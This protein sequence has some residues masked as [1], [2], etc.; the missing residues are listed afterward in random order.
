[1]SNAVETY[2]PLVIE[3]YLG[4]TSH[5]TTLQHGAYLLLLMA[6][7]RRGGALPDDDT[8]L[9]SIARLAPAEWRKHKPVLAEFF[10][11]AGGAW[12]QKRAEEELARA[13]RKSEAAAESARRRWEKD[14]G[15]D[16][17]PMRTHSG[18]TAKADA[19]PMRD[20][21][22]IDAPPSKNSPDANAS[23]RVSASRR[24]P[25]IPM[26]D[27]WAPKDR[28]ADAAEQRGINLAYQAQ[29]ARNWAA[30]NDARYADWDR[31]F[32]NWLLT[33][34]DDNGGQPRQQG[35]TSGQNWH[36]GN[37]D[38]ALASIRPQDRGGAAWSDFDG[39]EG[40]DRGGAA[41]LAFGPR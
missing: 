22:E 6:Y 1:M 7:W 13:R 10:Q 37:L 11:I 35:A 28:H 32:D 20:E 12:T 38:A 15:G 36:R 4:D 33:A 24:K 17:K 14:S 39:P 30:A 29:K 21:C 31:F 3:K 40:E 9:M 23:G 41:V 16:A 34:R 26:P 27:D 5:L 2:M 19:K 18:R 25:K 8:R